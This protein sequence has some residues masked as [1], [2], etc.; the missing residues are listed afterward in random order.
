[1]ETIVRMKDIPICTTLEYWKY[2]NLTNGDIYQIFDNIPSYIV[3]IVC[4]QNNI[5]CSW[6]NI[7]P[8]TS[9]R[10]DISLSSKNTAIVNLLSKYNTNNK[11]SMYR[12]DCTHIPPLPTY[13]ID[14]YTYTLLE[15]NLVPLSSIQ[16]FGLHES[17]PTILPYVLPFKNKE[18]V[19]V[20]IEDNGIVCISVEP[21]ED[22]Y[23][24]LYE[25]GIGI[26]NNRQYLFNHNVI[27]IRN[28]N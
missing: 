21:M 2:H 9:S 25:K 8:S 15:S 23:T 22:N 7:K 27:C 5:G 4:I 28:H 19:P 11:D 18:W 10:Y 1:M 12:S 13:T 17:D 24:Q 26:Y 14:S 16:P 3:W 20:S 6:Y